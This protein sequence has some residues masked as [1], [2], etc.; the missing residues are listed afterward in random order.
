ML[1]CLSAFWIH[2]PVLIWATVVNLFG[3]VCPLTTLEK[4]LLRAAGDEQYEEGFLIHYFGPLLNLENASR[5][6][7]IQTGVVILVWNIIVYLVVF[8]VL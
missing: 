1:I 8:F 6:L 5:K 2:I 7:E 4:K 3:W